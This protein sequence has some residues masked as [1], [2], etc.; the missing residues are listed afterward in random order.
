M[1]IRFK[2]SEKMA[3]FST[4]DVV[5]FEY[6]ET[7]KKHKNTKTNQTSKLNKHTE[8]NKMSFWSIAVDTFKNVNRNPHH[9]NND[10]YANMSTWMS[11]GYARV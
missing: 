6:Q 7:K 5:G 10:T 8:Q 1:E 11:K 3:T 4:T 2:E 9:Q